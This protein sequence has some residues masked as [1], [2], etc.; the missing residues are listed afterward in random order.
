MALL[1]GN[2]SET[3]RNSSDSKPRLN[4]RVEDGRVDWSRERMVQAANELATAAGDEWVELLDMFEFRK[5][6]C[7]MLY[8]DI[9]RYFFLPAERRY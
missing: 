4:R 5:S 9:R 3:D 2:A 8:I 6:L 7:K 1:C